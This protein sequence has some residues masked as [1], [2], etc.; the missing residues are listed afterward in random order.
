VVAGQNVY[1]YALTRDQSGSIPS[2]YAYGYD[3]LGR[4]TSVTLNGQQAGGSE[5]LSSLSGSM[6]TAP[7]ALGAAIGAGINGSSH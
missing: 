4:L 6:G 7:T 5:A 1:S 3:S 2:Q